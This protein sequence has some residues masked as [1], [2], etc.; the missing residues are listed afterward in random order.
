MSEAKPPKSNLS[1]LGRSFFS[2]LR[3]ALNNLYLC[4]THFL[5]T[6]HVEHREYFKITLH[7]TAE[8]FQDTPGLITR[9]CTQETPAW[10]GS[11]NHSL[12]VLLVLAP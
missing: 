4:T 7:S 10:D 8:R 3:S 5:R 6:S 2:D 12:A 9:T 11:Q 1:I